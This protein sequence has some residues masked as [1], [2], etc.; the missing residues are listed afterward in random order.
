MKAKELAELLLEH[1][2][3][4]VHFNVFDEDGRMFKF[5][6]IN[7]IGDI[8]YSEQVIVLEEEG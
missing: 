3:F 4:E 5:Y 7:G 1:P 6:V 2:E 8:S